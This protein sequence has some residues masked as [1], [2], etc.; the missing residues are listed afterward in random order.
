MRHAPV[1]FAVLLFLVLAMHAAS[2][3]AA[4]QNSIRPGGSYTV[5]V[6][7]HKPAGVRLVE[8]GWEVRAYF[9]SGT[10][11][12]N[13]GTWWQSGSEWIYSGWY[14]HRYKGDS[15]TGEPEDRTINIFTQVVPYPRPQDDKTHGMADISVG[16]SV[17]L[18]TRLL[19]KDIN[20]E[21]VGEETGTVTFT[22]GGVQYRYQYQTDE[23]GNITISG[24]GFQA[25]IK[26]Q[27]Y[28]PGTY[29]LR[30]DQ[31]M[32]VS[33]SND[34]PSS[35][36]IIVQSPI[37]LNLALLS[38]PESGFALPFGLKVI[39]AVIV[40]MGVVGAAAYLVLKGREKEEAPPPF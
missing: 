36:T 7:V 12:F 16:S 21:F 28:K 14:D 15:W 23:W 18:R 39:I 33:V 6:Q 9:Y 40:V 38:P 20:A 31:D 26:E 1:G 2:P 8:D 29:D 5:T 4:Q 25:S 34:A 37:N 22:I 32:S 35:G 19:I 11:C 10:S 17:M 24:E 27:S 3:V 30:I 13:T